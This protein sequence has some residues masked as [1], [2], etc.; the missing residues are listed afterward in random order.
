MALTEAPPRPSST[1]LDPAPAATV[2]REAWVTLAI[3]SAG[4]FVVFLDATVVNIA[5]P[6]IAAD[7][8][9]VSRAG[10]SWIL[11]A[12]AVVVGALLVTAGRFA[13]LRGRKKYFLSGLMLFALASVLCGL[14]PNV[15]F[16]VAARAIQ[17]I[18][19]AVM[20]PAS[21]GLILPAFP[22]A[23]RAVAVGIW[24]AAGSGA[25]AIGPSLGALLVEGPGWRWVFFINLPFGLLAGWA[26]A[27]LLSESR[28]PGAEPKLDLL[29]ILQVTATFGL[30]S[31][32]IVQGETWG[33]SSAGILGSFAAV[34]VLLP[35]LVRHAVKHPDPVLPITLFRSRSFSAA[36]SATLLF[37]AIFFA[38]L[39]C[40]VLFIT[41]V[42]H[43]SVLRTAMAVLPGP[44][45]ATVAAPIA[46]RIAD[47]KGHRFVIVPG[48]IIFGLGQVWLAT[49]M[50][51]EPSYLTALLPGQL[52]LGLGIGITFPTLGAAGAHSLPAELYAAGSAVTGVFR[53]LGSVLGV[54]VGIA[55]LGNPGPATVLHTFH[56]LWWVMGATA[57]V[58]AIVALAIGNTKHEQ[59]KQ[60]A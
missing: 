59:I 29:G 11:N 58:C 5:F 39:L 17:G 44:L 7:F 28:I 36:T 35:W 12:Y 60:V 49:H 13:D 8:S 48:A 38:N 54:A 43:Y 33:W 40:N 16:L 9:G 31:L 6:A 14:A 20:V 30:L 21:L 57:V 2:S 53:Q 23:K 47:A 19:A 27:R 45:L 22:A 34:A 25:A 37:A 32:A 50:S 46:G 42:W 18:G 15:P 51:I 10:L 4:V 41:G 52:L 56:R 26:G 24:G 3:A 1:P 55:L